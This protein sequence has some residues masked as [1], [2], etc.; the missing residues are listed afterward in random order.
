MLKLLE[1]VVL[2]IE[3]KEQTVGGFVLQDQPKKTA[4]QRSEGLTRVFKLSRT[5]CPSVL[6]QVLVEAHA[7]I[8]VKDGDENMSSWGKLTS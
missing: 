6:D 5:S 8:D 7:G 4:G 3:E 1:T 2:K